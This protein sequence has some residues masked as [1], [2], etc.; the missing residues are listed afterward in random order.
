MP[1]KY[2]VVQFVPNPTAEERVNIGVMTWDHV[3]VRSQF[4]DNW[5]R[6]RAFSAG[7]VG[8]VRDIAAELAGRTAAQGALPLDDVGRIDDERMEALARK[9]RHCIQFT[10]PRGSLKNADDLLAELAPVFL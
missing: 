9:W 10:P 6:V 7:E 5:R 3:G 1:S 4:L 2:T 8:F